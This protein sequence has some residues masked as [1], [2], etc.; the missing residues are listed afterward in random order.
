MGHNGTVSASVESF[1]ANGLLVTAAADSV[2]GNVRKVNE[3]SIL[4]RPGAYAVA[5]GMGGHNAGDVASRLTIASLEAFLEEASGDVSALSTV[6]Q[7]A[8]DAVR[9]HADESG[10]EGMGSTLV[11]ALAVANG[12]EHSVV[13]INVGDSRCYLS[14][15]G[16]LQQLT[17]DHS[18]VQELV[19]RGVI[20]RSEA[21]THPERNVVTRAIGVEES[22]LGDFYV[23]PNE[24]T[25]RMLLCS[26]GV[27]GE[28]TDD[29]LAVVLREE[30]DPRSA[31]DRLLALVLAGP[32]RDNASAAVIDLERSS[33]VP[34]EARSLDTDITG[35]R[36][37]ESTASP[38]E[39][40][41]LGSHSGLI[42]TVPITSATAVEVDLKS[43]LIDGVPG[44]RGE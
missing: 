17:K 29:E 16:E 1:S 23:V 10:N 3:D 13:V 36:R 2:T 34:G 5:D 38:T 41:S 14:I 43:A 30:P 33:A 19:D 8:N 40:S 26:D 28:L 24:P 18:H 4:I 27:S 25:V 22:V 6:V 39:D 21:A 31:V 7:R 42:A 44:V 12:D 11:C 9:S 35:P 32:A 15:G 20:S 37:M